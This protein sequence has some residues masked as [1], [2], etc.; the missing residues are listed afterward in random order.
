MTIKDSI[1]KVFGGGD[2]STS[3]TSNTPITH[4]SGSTATTGTTAHAPVGTDTV[5]QHRTVRAPDAHV[6]AG[7]AAGTRCRQC[8]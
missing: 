8:T 4:H 2:S 5:E 3:T 1:K 6:P 7:T